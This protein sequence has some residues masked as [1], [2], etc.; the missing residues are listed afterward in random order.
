MKRASKRVVLGEGILDLVS[1]LGIRLC[2][3]RGSSLFIVSQHDMILGK[4]VRLVAEI[5]PARRGKS[6]KK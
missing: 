6:A 1:D 2:D 5:L 4:R 3:K